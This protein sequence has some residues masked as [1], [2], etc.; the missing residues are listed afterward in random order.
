MSKK[1]KKKGQIERER[2]E[3]RV[4]KMPAQET[5]IGR[6]GAK[7]ETLG[8][9]IVHCWKIKI[10]LLRLKTNHEQLCGHS[11]ERKEKK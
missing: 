5:N 1:E 3:N 7:L 6:M 8:E 11:V 9:G 4:N 2:A 10:E